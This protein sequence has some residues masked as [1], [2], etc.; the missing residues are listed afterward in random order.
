[1]ILSSEQQA[2]VRASLSRR[3][4]VR[5]VAGS[6]KTAVLVE[7]ARF[8][9]GR[10]KAPL[11]PQRIWFLSF[12]RAAETELSTRLKAAKL[13]C[14]TL[15]LHS[16]AQRQLGAKVHILSDESRVWKAVLHELQRRHS[17]FGQRVAQELELLWQQPFRE[18][19]ADQEA[20]LQDAEHRIQ[21]ISERDEVQYL[22]FT[23]L[24]VELL[25]V[26]EAEPN[27]LAEVQRQFDHL[28]VDE[29]QDVSPLQAQVI[30]TLAGETSL[31]VVGDPEQSIFSFQGSRP[32]VFEA[33]WEE[34]DKRFLLADNFRSPGAHLLAAGQLVSEPLVPARGFFGSLQ[35]YQSSLEVELMD[36]LQREVT[37]LVS[38]LEP[39]EVVV[40]V[41][42]NAHGEQ[43]AQLLRETG[44]SVRT[45]AQ[46]RRKWSGWV[47]EVLWPAVVFLA[48]KRVGSHPLTWLKDLNLEAAERQLLRTAWQ[49][50]V[51][52]ESVQAV[53]PGQPRL[54]A[55][56]EALEPLE[57]ISQLLK[58]STPV[59]SGR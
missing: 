21:V 59:L 43:A 36:A 14:R 37:A 39:G 18:R 52:R 35:V 30:E 5:A 44:L 45:T 42:E 9:A 32:A 3:M 12:T 34:A 57:N 33:F 19:T 55:L 40:L 7:R 54:F 48:G 28:I 47:R 24:L 16:F 25:R 8:L 11:P 31:L 27:R 53:L 4:V 22:T 6:G 15:T 17:R 46:A 51:T 58:G 41:R 10:L 56:W 38:T 23:Q 20:L 50:E 49:V 26:W 2:V 29:Y 13:P 1:M